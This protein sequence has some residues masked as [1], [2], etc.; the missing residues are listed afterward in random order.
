ML[1]SEG[2]EVNGT[3]PDSTSSRL[4]ET[5]RVCAS[6]SLTVC[7]YTVPQTETYPVASGSF[8][9]VGSCSKYARSFPRSPYAEAF[10]TSST[11]GVGDPRT[12]AQCSAVCLSPSPS[13]TSAPLSSRNDA[14]ATRLFRA[15]H[16]SGRNLCGGD[17]GWVCRTNEEEVSV[18]K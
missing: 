18:G 6:N 3:C 2:W 9:S 16:C 1:G 13:E 15:A 12:H 4:A 7:S 8:T 10:H 14:T 5:D 11:A 17:G